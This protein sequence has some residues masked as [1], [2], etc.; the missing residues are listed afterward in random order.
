MCS[1]PAMAGHTRLIAGQEGLRP[2]VASQRLEG[3]TSLTA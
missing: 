2:E 1:G 3:G